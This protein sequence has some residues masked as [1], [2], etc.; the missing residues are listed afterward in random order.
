MGIWGGAGGPKAPG[1]M[2]L[3]EAVRLGSLGERL[4]FAID[5]VGET[6]CGTVGDAD[7]R[8]RRRRRAV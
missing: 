5:G 8:Q 3:R 4:I 7:A 6:G 1:W 2:S